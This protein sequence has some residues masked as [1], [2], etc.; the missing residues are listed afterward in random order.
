MSFAQFKIIL[1]KLKRSP[2]E[3]VYFQSK[4]NNLMSHIMSKIASPTWYSENGL[5]DPN[6]FTVQDHIC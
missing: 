4:Q 6:T 2:L 1:Q 3:K 5:L